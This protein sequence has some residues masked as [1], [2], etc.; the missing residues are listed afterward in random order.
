M[1]A[2][3][4]RCKVLWFLDSARMG[5]AERMAALLA[6]HHD[7]QRL[8]LRLAFWSAGPSSLARD[9]D[10]SGVEVL[11]LNA[12]RRAD[13]AAALRGLLHLRRWRPHVIHLHLTTATLWGGWAA[14]LLGIPAA[15]TLH[16][17]PSDRPSPAGRLERLT[18]RRAVARIFVLSPAQR[19]A[20]AAAGLPA[21]R[22]ELLPHG[23][24]AHSPDPSAARLLR[25]R[26]GLAP[27]DK[28]WLTTAVVRELKGWR[29]WLEAA[30]R[31]AACDPA[32]H[33]AWLGDGPEYA[34]FVRAA[35][36]RLPPLRLH[37]PGEVARPAPWYDASDGFIFPTRQEAQPTVLLEAM[38]AGLPVLASDIAANREV[39]G[40]AGEYFCPGSTP[41]LFSQWRRWAADSRL[42]SAR[43]QAGSRRFARDFSLSGWLSR[44]EAHYANLAALPAPLPGA[45]SSAEFVNVS[46]LHDG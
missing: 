14:R 18:L 11:W 43:A 44:L 37:L 33:F 23:L 16:V 7:R 13:P 26:L 34:A 35:R 17:S 15:A 31:L 46:P 21:S 42:R 8:D 36:A 29:E 40:E 2:S 1:N 25:T 9:F 24:P 38:A 30:A 27:G 20:W 10:A 5:G 12:R 4:G 45:S 39:L 6:R 22:L 28:L 41:A 32:A 19:Q 3:N